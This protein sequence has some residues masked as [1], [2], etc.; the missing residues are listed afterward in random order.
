MSRLR[1]RSQ[2]RENQESCPG[3]PGAAFLRKHFGAAK[4]RPR[5]MGLLLAL[6]TLLA[7]WPVTRNGFVNYDDNDYVTENRIVQNGL[8]WVGVKWALTTGH[9]GNWHPVTWLSHMLDCELFGLNAGAQHYVNILFHAANAV[10]LFLLLLRLTRE[11]WPSLFVAALFAWHPLHVESVAWIAERKD[12]LSTFFALLTLLAYVKAVTSDRGQVTRTNSTLSRFTFHVSRF[13]WLALVFFTL[14]LMAKP[15]LVTLPFVMLLLDYW[16]LQRMPDYQFRI[17]NL[18]RLTLEKWPFFLLTIISCVV[19]YLVQHHSE[20]VVTLQQYPLHPRLANALI[21]YERY[22]GKTFWPSNLAVLYPLP[23]NRPWLLAMAATA[24]AVLGVIS[25]L[26]WRMRRQCPCLLVGWLWF[27]GTLVPVIGL[28]QVGSAAM[29][30]RYTYFPLV[31]VFIA[32]AFG[33]RDL[34]N[35]FQIPIAAV[36]TAAAMTLAG[37]LVLTENQLRYWRDSESLFVHALAA[38]AEDNL[39]ARINYG[40][41]LDQKGR[42]AEALIQYRAVARVATN[43]VEAHYN[44]GNLLDKMGQPK[45]ALLELQKAV[46]LDPKLATAH[47][48]LGAVL[49]KLGRLNEA[50]SQFAEAVRL[51]PAYPTAHFDLGKLLLKQ[52]RDARAMDEFRTALRLD[53][54]NFQFLAYTARVLA[55]DDHPEI[56]DGKTALRLATR[57][58]ALTDGGQPVVLDVLGMAFAE[59]GDFT[60]A[61]EVTQSAIDLAMAGQMKQIEPVRQRLELYKNHQPWRESFLATNAP[62]KH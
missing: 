16:P 3:D 51:D 4:A 10:L 1:G 35:R 52:G 59:T 17:P 11:L 7:Y 60:R 37:C 62:A 25:W 43:S 39:Y 49:A 32:V 61:Q 46:R 40:T 55:A 26:V 18:K 36:V 34:A 8:T 21:A 56:R 42:W 58:N 30:D 6:I 53:P 5:L 9:A 48:V 54:D 22:L 12:L 29:A 31:G 47:D 50:M 14:G 41:A 44:I 57:A 19:T 45:A 27:L 24:A 33:L 20:A 23:F 38:T 28:V 15:M 2:N 13:Y